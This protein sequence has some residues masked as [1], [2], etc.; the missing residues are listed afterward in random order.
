[1]TSGGHDVHDAYLAWRYFGE[2]GGLGALAIAM[3]VQSH[4]SVGPCRFGWGIGVELL[5]TTGGF[6]ITT[7]LLRERARTG[8][9][10]LH[11]FHVRRVLQVLVWFADRDPSARAEFFLNLPAYVTFTAKVRF[12]RPWWF[13]VVLMVAMTGV[14]NLAAYLLRRPEG[15]RA[16]RHVVDR[17]GVLRWPLHSSS[18]WPGASFREDR[19]SPPSSDRS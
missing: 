1:M 11:D 10:S 8:T 13:P 15:F 16:A 9:I 17:P 6:L 12:G 18:T 2:L 19:G 7:L 3:V 5:F 4:S 14:A